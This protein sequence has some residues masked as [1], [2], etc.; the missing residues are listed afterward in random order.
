[1]AVTIEIQVSS[2]GL[3][4]SHFSTLTTLPDTGGVFSFAHTP[5]VPGQLYIYRA[6]RRDTSLD[7]T[8]EY[9][10]WSLFAYARGPY[11]ET[12]D[13]TMP[14]P[15]TGARTELGIGLEATEGT[16]VRSQ[17]KLEYNNGK[18]EPNMPPVTSRA[19]RATPAANKKAIHGPASFAGDFVIEAT[20]EG[21]FSKVL[22]GAFGTPTFT[23][24]IQGAG[25]PT[26]YKHTFKNRFGQVPVTFVQKLMD[27]PGAERYQVSLGSRI[28][29]IELGFDA[30][31]TTPLTASIGVMSLDGSVEFSSSSSVGM[32]T[33]SVDTLQPLSQQDATITVGGANYCKTRRI[34]VPVDKGIGERRGLCGKRGAQG[35]FEGT[36]SVGPI[37]AD[38]YFEDME[39]INR[40]Y[41]TPNVG[42]YP[43]AAS[44]RIVGTTV[45]ITLRTPANA[46]GYQN[47][48]EITFPNAIW[49]SVSTPVSGD[50]EITQTVT[51]IPLYSEADGTDVILDWWNGE[52]HQSLCATGTPIS[53]MPTS[54][55]Y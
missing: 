18:I 51:M 20:P 13:N 48:T 35:H 21:G 1:M 42:T 49:E 16:A 32:D 27:T 45:K 7:P 34:T 23:Q 8:C 17:K 53:G 39:E 4:D 41:G 55:V 12:G 25:T 2:G 15:I 38:M 31:A 10:E 14:D 5:V 26:H 33:A 46:T 44:K 37:T 29:S 6:R 3:A 50:G 43:V 28:S 9:S 52:T 19:L 36:S 30:E 11:P 40:L 24:T 47:G 22:V 54:Q